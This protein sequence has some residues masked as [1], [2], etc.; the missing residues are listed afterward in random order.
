[1]NFCVLSFHGCMSKIIPIDS[2]SVEEI[3]KQLIDLDGATPH[4]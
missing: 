3:G 1:M 4:M 2:P